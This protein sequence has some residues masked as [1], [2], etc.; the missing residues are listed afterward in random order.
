MLSPILLTLFSCLKN[1]E[2][3][4][5]REIQGSYLCEFF[6]IFPMAWLFLRHCHSFSTLSAPSSHLQVIFWHCRAQIS[7]GQMPWCCW[8]KENMHFLC[9]VLPVLTCSHR[10]SETQSLTS[11]CEN[12][13]MEATIP[14][15]A[16]FLQS[17]SGKNVASS[18]NNPSSSAVEG[19]RHPAELQLLFS[20][21]RNY[22]RHSSPQPVWSQ[23]RGKK[24]WQ[25][26]RD[27]MFLFPYLHN[28]QK[29]LL[30]P[31]SGLGKK[32]PLAVLH[33][34]GSLAPQELHCSHQRHWHRSNSPSYGQTRYLYFVQMFWQFSVHLHR[35]KMCSTIHSLTVFTVT[36]L[37]QGRMTQKRICWQIC[38][39]RIP[40]NENS[41]P[42][43]DRKWNSHVFSFLYDV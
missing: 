8:N 22:R 31:P 5:I 25:S 9:P 10:R 18:L 16:E 37:V 42:S 38:L 6:N 1:S 11:D 35:W 24:G 21:A 32:H 40:L 13:T 41:I 12:S 28:Q 33:S 36:V 3:C 17:S 27:P 26:G 14:F 43:T 4:W 20:Q 34:A 2:I 29:I 39:V 7:L 23:H 19:C 30:V 15:M